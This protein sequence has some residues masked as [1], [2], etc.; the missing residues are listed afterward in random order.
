MKTSVSIKFNSIEEYR[1]IENKLIELGYI[2][3]KI[4]NKR[5]TNQI[6]YVRIYEDLIFTNFKNI[7]GDVKK[8]YNSLEEFLKDWDMEEM[9]EVECNMCGSLMWYDEEN[10]I[11]VCT[12]SECTRCYND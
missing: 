6:G 3:D 2:S 7:S 1:E 12:D 8:I 5:K 10:G 9:E 4:W 11:H